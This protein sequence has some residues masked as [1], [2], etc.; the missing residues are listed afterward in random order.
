VRASTWRKVW[1]RRY[2]MWNSQTADQ[3]GNK[4]WSIKIRLKNKDNRKL[5]IKRCLFFY[6]Y[7]VMALI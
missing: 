7:N 1:G 4:N 6:R 5:K 3:K 2:G